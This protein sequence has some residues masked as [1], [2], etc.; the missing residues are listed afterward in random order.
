MQIQH[1]A[2]KSY[3]RRSISQANKKLNNLD[4]INKILKVENKKQ[5]GHKIA[6]SVN[7]LRFA[8]ERLIKPKV[9]LYDG[10]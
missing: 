4:K 7:E 8:T 10:F 5:K 9:K 2:L 3:R 6:P 1:L